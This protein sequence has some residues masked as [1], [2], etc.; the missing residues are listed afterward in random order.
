MANKNGTESVKLP[1]ETVEKVRKHVNK[2]RPKPSIG[3]V[4]V[5]AIDKYLTKTK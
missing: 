4:I 5:V 3:G 1:A 2:Q